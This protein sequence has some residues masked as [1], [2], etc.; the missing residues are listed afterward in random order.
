MEILVLNGSPRVKGNTA[1]MI[2]AFREAAEKRGHKVTVVDVCRKQIRGCLACEYCHGKGQGTCIQKDDM[3]EIYEKLRT[4]GMLVLASPIYYHGITGQLKC[5]I[6]R[7]YSALYP[8]A[9]EWIIILISMSP[10]ARKLISK[11]LTILAPAMASSAGR[12]LKLT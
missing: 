1:K 9:P 8:K 7:F 11:L 6:D 2:A 3:Q 5:V 4:A 12:L 10:M